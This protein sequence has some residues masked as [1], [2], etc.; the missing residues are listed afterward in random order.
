MTSGSD[1]ETAGA[2]AAA[3]AAGASPS[4]FN[5]PGPPGGPGA[6]PGGMLSRAMSPDSEIGKKR[7]VT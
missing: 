7:V 6:R 1:G 4:L 3:A 5:K 2:G